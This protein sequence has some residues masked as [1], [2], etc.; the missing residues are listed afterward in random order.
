MKSP[1]QLLYDTVFERLSMLGFIVY[2][3]LP[4][5]EVPYP[6]IVIKNNLS[7][8]NKRQKS[9]RSMALSLKID[10]WHLSDNRGEHDKTLTQIE[11]SLFSLVSIEG[12]PLVVRDLRT[13]E[14]TDTT[15]KDSLL[16]GIIDV[17]YQ[18]I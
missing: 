10:T 9:N 12:L 5:E 18:I 17:T 1:R 14:M 15:T 2:D 3:K 8:Y 16:H 7:E 6:F 13:N 4:M 11:Q